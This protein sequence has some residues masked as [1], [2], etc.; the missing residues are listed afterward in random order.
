MTVAPAIE[1]PDSRASIFFSYSRVDQKRAMPIIAALEHA[2]FKVWWDG[3][4][5]GGDTFLP[6][7]EAALENAT[8]VVVLWSKTSV[9]SHW[10]RD[11]ATSGRERGCLIPLSL[12]KT[13]APLGFRQFQLIDMS[14]W[15]GKSDAPEFVRLMR[16]VDAL[17]GSQVERLNPR[18]SS[19]LSRRGLIGGGIALG[20]VG[21]VGLAAWQAGLIGG[22]GAAINSIAVLPFDN[23]SRESEQAYFADGLVAELRA[24]LSRNAALRVVAQASSDA[25]RDSRDDARTIAKR[26]GVAFLLGGNVRIGDGKVRI[27]ADLTDGFTGFNR[28]SKTFEQPLDNVIKVQE[29]IAGSVT[30]ALTSEVAADASKAKRQAGG[31][32]NVAAYD[33]YLRGRDLYTS[34]T[35]EAGERAALARFD[36]ALEIDPKF[37]FAHAA[38][39]RSLLTIGN[40]YGSAAQVRPLYAAAALAAQRAVEIAPDYAEGWSSLGVVLFQGQLKAGAARQPFEKSRTLGSGE[41]TVSAR[42]AS[43]ASA[44]GR[45]AEAREAI[46]RAL[47]L[48]PFNPLICRQEGQVHYQARRYEAALVSA[49]E[50]MKLDP[51]MTTANANIGDALFA[52]GQFAE[53]RAAY[54]KEP[55]AMLRETGLAVVMLRLGNRGAASAARDKV[56]AGLGTGQ[57]TLYQQAQIAAQWGELDGAQALLESAFATVDSGLTYAARDPLLDPLRRT[58]AFLNLLNRI[59]F[60]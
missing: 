41:A 58:P 13:R 31:T 27:L 32:E 1:P 5:E 22:S 35:D 54:L 4:L 12:D 30:A 53:A 25:F 11:E 15:H 17:H 16:A 45:D 6:T 33:N 40:Q 56:I 3:L 18:P 14:R 52:L 49:R 57:L 21:V 55:S 20:T 38:R 50:A 34:A 7:T 26:L 46:A 28:W 37:A 9:G 60:A 43:Y 42:Y 8:A 48:D 51:A 47:N 2:G 19:G 39:A 10:V 44:N 59:G 23:L 29:E 24:G 36:A